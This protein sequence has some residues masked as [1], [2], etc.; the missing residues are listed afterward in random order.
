MV[1]EKNIETLFN[2]LL[3]T[4]DEKKIMKIVINEDN[5]ENIIKKLVEG[6]SE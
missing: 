2:T 3:E 5:T 4:D 1:E 6:K